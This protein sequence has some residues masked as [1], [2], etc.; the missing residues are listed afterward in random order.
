MSSVAVGSVEQR[1]AEE[2]EHRA[3][4]REEEIAQRGVER[5]GATLEG[6]ERHRGEGQ[7]LERDIEIEQ[8]VAEEDGIKRSP[9]TA[10]EAS[11]T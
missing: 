6:H 9:T 10:A 5:L 2:I 8:V 1:R 4:E 7:E 3:R 11:R